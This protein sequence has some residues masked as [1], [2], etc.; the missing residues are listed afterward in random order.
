[1]ILLRTAEITWLVEGSVLF[2]DIQADD[3]DEL[4]LRDE[5]IVACL[6]S[7]QNTVDL[8]LRM[9]P[10]TQTK[11]PSLKDLTAPRYQKHP[12]LGLVILVGIAK[13]PVARFLTASLATLRG[14]SLHT[15]ETLEEAKSFLR[16][17]HPDVN[18]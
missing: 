7:T 14:L 9:S 4:T 15:V 12:R 16:I 18:L 8:I 17:R 1:M 11:P 2:M 6:D 3:P 10:S 13:N 5:A